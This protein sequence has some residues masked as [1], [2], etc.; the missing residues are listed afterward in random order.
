M[1]D[2]PRLIL[3]THWKQIIMSKDEILCKCKSTTKLTL[4]KIAA[5]NRLVSVLVINL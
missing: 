4:K 2:S 3:E 5:K 1:L